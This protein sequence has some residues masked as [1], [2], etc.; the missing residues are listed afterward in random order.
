MTYNKPKIIS[1]GQTG[2]DTIALEVALELGYKTEGFCPKGYMTENGPDPFLLR[3]KFHL[4]EM[5][6]SSYPARTIANIKKADLTIIFNLKG[7][8]GPAGGA[9]GRSGNEVGSGTLKTQHCALTGNWPKYNPSLPPSRS[10]GISVFENLKIYNSN[11]SCIIFYD[12]ENILEDRNIYKV[13]SLIQSSK[14][15]NIAGPRGSKLASVNGSEKKI[16]EV[17]E[18]LLR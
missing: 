6:T 1:G 10:T 9:S 14:I 3:D 12:I 17:L 2:V 16:R 15:I 11:K 7:A 13:R 5:E 8:S 4:E 18:I